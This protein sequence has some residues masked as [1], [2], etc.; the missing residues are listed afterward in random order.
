V[1]ELAAAEPDR[2]ISKAKSW[3]AS[4]ARNITFL[5]TEPGNPFTTNGLSKK[6]R[7]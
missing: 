1:G 5:V 3:L 4:H 2:I 6:I 7:D